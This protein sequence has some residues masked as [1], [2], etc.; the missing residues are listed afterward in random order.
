MMHLMCVYTV[1]DWKPEMVFEKKFDSK[2]DT[3]NSFIFR[4]NIQRTFDFKKKLCVHRKSLVMAAFLSENTM[5]HYHMAM[6]IDIFKFK[7]PEHKRYA[8]YN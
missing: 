1:V 8:K 6:S 3:I 4:V 5:W 2:H 7:L